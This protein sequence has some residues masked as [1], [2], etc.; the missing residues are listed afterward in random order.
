[1]QILSKIKENG[2]T[3]TISQ[4]GSMYSGQVRNIKTKLVESTTTNKSLAYVEGYLTGKM[5][6]NMQ[7]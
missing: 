4:N 7:S 2:K 5:L 1:M 6:R 3:F